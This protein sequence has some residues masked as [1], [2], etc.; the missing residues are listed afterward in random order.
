MPPARSGDGGAGA[1]PGTPGARP[2]APGPRPTAGRGSTPDLGIGAASP[3]L[4]GATRLPRPIE[5]EPIEPPSEA[6]GLASVNEPAPATRGGAAPGE[7]RPTSNIGARP[8]R[9]TR[10]GATG[11]GTAAATSRS[12]SGTARAGRRARQRSYA[13]RSFFERYRSLIVGGAAVAGL[14]IFGALVFLGNSG[15]AYACTTMVTEESPAA[16][17]G[18]A[19]P[20]IGQVEPDMGRNHVVPGSTV[21]YLYCPP[22]SGTHFNIAGRGP[23]QPR[24]YGPDDD[25]QPMG[26]VHN[27]EHGGAA[28]L[29]SC[30]NGACDQADLDQLR[31]LASNFPASP[32]CSVPGGV[33]SP[34]I[35]RFDDMT[36]RFAAVVW[37]RVLLQN[38]LDTAA[39]LEF[40]RRYAERNNPEKQCQAPQSTPVVTTGCPL[41][42]ASAGAS[43]SPAASGSPTASGSPAASGSVAPSAAATP[44]ASPTSS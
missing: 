17:V 41:P 20:E 38:E 5:P 24:F 36:T 11:T 30:K 34:V 13:E 43:G 4:S 10:T 42:S 8:H 25:A 19:S 7:A 21:N 26:W 35:A 37:D 15:N 1:R 28:I 40:Y 22:A 14:V 44:A 12:A 6:E 33:L 31:Q 9:S 18:S 23:I 39:I 16:P 3:R 2:G 32:L 29:Y 27:L